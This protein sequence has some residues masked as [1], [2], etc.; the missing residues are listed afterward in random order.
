[1]RTCRQTLHTH[2]SNRYEV[3][4]YDNPEKDSNLTQAGCKPCVEVVTNTAMATL[5]AV[6]AN[7]NIMSSKKWLEEQKHPQT[8]HYCRGLTSFNHHQ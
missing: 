4:N 3:L 1:M 2:S 8:L 7:I 6:G 5:E